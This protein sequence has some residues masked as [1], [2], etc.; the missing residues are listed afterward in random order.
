M[1]QV[2]IISYSSTYCLNPLHYLLIPYINPSHRI[3]CFHYRYYYLL[4]VVPISKHKAGAGSRR[5]SSFVGGMLGGPKPPVM[6]AADQAKLAQMYTT[7][8]KMSSENKITSKNSWDLNLIDHMGQLIK[9]DT[10]HRGVNFQKA[11]CTLDASVKIYSN[12]VD[13]TWTSSYRIL[14]NLSR[15]GTSGGDGEEGEERGPAR[16]GSKSISS[17]NGLTC[18]IES[19]KEK[20]NQVKLDSDYN[21]DPMFHKMSMAFDEGGAK[22]MLMNNLR[23]VPGSSTL[24]FTNDNLVDDLVVAEE[25]SVEGVGE[26]TAMS[27]ESEKEVAVPACNEMIDISQILLK[28]GITCAGLQSLDVAPALDDYRGILGVPA[29]DSGQ[30]DASNLNL[31][32]FDSSIEVQKIKATPTVSSTDQYAADDNFGCEDFGCEDDDGDSDDANDGYLHDDIGDNGNEYT[33]ERR[34]SQAKP[35]IPVPSQKLDWNTLFTGDDQSSVN[36][37][38]SESTDDSSID[39][40]IAPASE[41]IPSAVGNDYTFLNFASM[42]NTNSWAGARHWKFAPKR[43][44]AGEKVANSSSSTNDTKDDSK[45]K[46]ASATGD[47]KSDDHSYDNDKIKKSKDMFTFDFHKVMSNNDAAALKVDPK[48][49]AS[50]VISQAAV[51]KANE[52]AKEGAYTLPHDAKLGPKDLCRLF[53]SPLMIVPPTNMKSIMD[54]S[55][56]VTLSSKIEGMVSGQQDIMWGNMEAAVQA[57]LQNFTSNSADTSNKDDNGYDDDNDGDNF[58]YNDDDY[59]DMKAPAPVL[60][61]VEDDKLPKDTNVIGVEGGL[62]I[63]VDGMLQAARKVEK[64]NIGYSTISKRVNVKNLKTEIWNW[65]D[66]ECPEKTCNGK[67]GNENMK[68]NNKSSTIPEGPT[69][70][71]SLEEKD[72]SASFQDMISNIAKNNQR[73]AGQEVSVSYYFICLLH[74]ANEKGL[75]I[76]DQNNFS[77][78]QISKDL[79]KC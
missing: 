21:A 50:N 47:K 29:S 78:L 77:D 28:S 57:K 15:N 66:S 19:D 76:E 44:A 60:S 53:C 7:I 9:E 13:D 74:L 5:R 23:V 22:G 58:V 72:S 41:F 51:D 24:V 34:K 45:S 46:N 20:L 25:T 69:K 37:E 33:S 68:P 54:P 35:V 59:D 27:V 8:I 61:D 62:E 42:N 56:S 16:V 11:S 14:E 17:R 67:N 79:I 3:W 52:V 55:S 4:R 75:K 30:F 65:V 43:V 38:R 6:N 26:G 63:R 10:G 36:D 49:L 73:E 40:A 18:T 48:K 12:R 39:G 2:Y 1:P 31:T 71:K 70:R 64:I 32:E